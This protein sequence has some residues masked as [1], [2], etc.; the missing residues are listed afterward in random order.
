MRRFLIL[1]VVVV[2]GCSSTATPTT[3]TSEN[4]TQPLP[5]T[6]TSIAAQNVEVQDCSS[7]T[8]TFSTF[9]EVYELLG[10]WHVDR[11]LDA[12][13]LAAIAM[14]GLEEFTTED[15]E[16]RPRTLFCSIPSEE[17]APMCEGLAQR[18]T[19][20]QIPAGLAVEAALAHMTDTGLDP[21]TYYLPPDQAGNFRLNG[22]V[23][24]IGVLLDARDAAG[25]KCARITSICQLQVVT[26]LENNPGFEAGLR[27]GDIITHID[28]ETVDG[29]GFASVVAEIAGDET[30]LI[31]LSVER[32]GL[33][34][35]FAIER[36]ELVVPT[37]EVGIP[38]DDIAYISIPDFESDITGLVDSAIAEIESLA[39]TVVVDL[40]DNPGGFIDTV[41]EVAD[42][43]VD[44]GIVM[45]SE[46]PDEFLEYPANPGGSIISERLVVLVNSGTAS[47]G[48]ILAGALRDRR[49]A[50]IV[51]TNTFGKD[52]VQIPFTLRNGGELYVAVARWSTPNG[53][54]VGDGGLTPDRF[55]EWPIGAP[56]EDIVA[57]ALEAAS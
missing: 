38:V 15:V 16:E 41:I 36:R 2:V 14:A 47:A 50:T 45:I 11:P 21:F 9:C 23:G 30:G 7:P 29:L 37:V 25:S 10:D 34:Q 12:S 48:E 18:M 54:T 40:R 13:V 33:A 4:Q 56:I 5:S 32:D 53:D 57:L 26:V 24:G 22:I 19:E 42:R 35:E 55:V 51:G 43:F 20:S 17:F 27:E 52:A 6:T 1:L 46:G 28:G 8:V 44:G 49:G 3:V 31:N 39:T